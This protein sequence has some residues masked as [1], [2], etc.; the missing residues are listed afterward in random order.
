[1]SNTPQ[2]LLLKSAPGCDPDSVCLQAL[3]RELHFKDAYRTSNLNYSYERISRSWDFFKC[4][5]T[6]IKLDLAF[7]EASLFAR[8]SFPVLTSKGF[9]DPILQFANNTPATWLYGYKT[10]IVKPRTCLHQETPFYQHGK[11]IL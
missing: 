8:S 6:K 2:S 7:A 10:K 9:P 3:E 5:F 11:P 1:M 4:P